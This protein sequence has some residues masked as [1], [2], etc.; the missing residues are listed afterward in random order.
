[1]P[2][3]N[4]VGLAKA[5]AQKYTPED[6]ALWLKVGCT[7][8]L[9]CLRNQSTQKKSIIYNTSRRRPAGV[10]VI[11]TVIVDATDFSYGSG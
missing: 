4:T 1:M 9:K 10:R 6:S 11:R 8:T 5:G 3:M 2:F 7:F